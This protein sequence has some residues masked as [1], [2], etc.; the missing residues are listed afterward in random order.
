MKK[1][2]TTLLLITCIVNVK[3]YDNSKFSVNIPDNYKEEIIGENIYKWS[4]DNNYISVTISPNA[5]NYN[6]INYTN[7]DLINQKEHMESTYNELLSEENIKVSVSNMRKELINDNM[8]LLYD[9]YWPTKSS[10]GYD[11]YQLGETYTSKNYIFTLL[12][13]SDK[14]LNNEEVNN[15]LNSFIIKDEINT[16]YNY[17][18]LI[19]FILIVGS[20]LGV[21]GYFISKKNK[22]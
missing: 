20:I 22:K 5:E 17:S 14:E 7:E 11:T 3:A 13:S 9:I 2:F 8:V 19:K 12:I 18:A 15:I 10:I 21:I 1:L 16:N 4:Y 6:V